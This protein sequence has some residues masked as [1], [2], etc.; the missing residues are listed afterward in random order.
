MRKRGAFADLVHL[1]LDDSGRCAQLFVVGD[2][3]R[4]F[5]D[6]SKSSAS[7]GFP[8]GSA[9]LKQRY[10]DRFGSLDTPIADVRSTHAAHVEIVALGTVIPGVAALLACG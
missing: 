2:E 9:H 3:S 10:T 1:A 6:A 5:L 7:W 4:R 8:R